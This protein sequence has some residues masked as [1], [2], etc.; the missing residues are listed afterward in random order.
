M[1][2][3]SFC[4]DHFRSL[5][6]IASAT[7][8]VTLLI[9]LRLFKS[10]KRNARGPESEKMVEDPARASPFQLF[11]A[12]ATYV[13]NHQISEELNYVYLVID[14]WLTPPCHQPSLLRSPTRGHSAMIPLDA[15][16]H[17]SCS[18]VQVVR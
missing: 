5:P 6:L 17:T 8:L 2:T 13:F 18:G 14:S 1:V 15:S 11:I 9:A 10:S 3:K 16:W 4:G 7:G 12:M